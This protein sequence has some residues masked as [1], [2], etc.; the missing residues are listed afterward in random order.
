MLEDYALK[1]PQILLPDAR[2]DLTKWAVVACDQYTSQPDYWRRVQTLVGDAPSALNLI[3]PEAW[4]D[5]GDGR[6]DAINRAMRDYETTVLTRTITGFVLVERTIAAGRRLGLVAAVDLEQYDFSRGAQSLIRP[7]EGTILERIPPR[8]RI[9]QRASLE[10]P[11]ILLLVDDPARTLIEP[12]YAARDGLEKLYDFELMAGGG[13]IRGWRVGEEAALE[14]ALSGLMDRAEGLLFAVGDGN[15]SLAT[16]R[17]CWLNIRE[18][19]SP[20][21][22]QTHPARWALA[23]INNLHDPALVFEP[24]HRALFGADAQALRRDFAAWLAGRGMA[25]R[26]CA[27]EKAMFTL[28]A[29]GVDWPLRVEGLKNPLP[30]ATLQPFLDEWLAGQA[31]VSID[32]IHGEDA[33]RDLAKEGAVGILLPAM[34]KH[35]LFE[36]VRRGGPLPR[37]TFSMG[38]ANEKRY[39]LEARKIT[40]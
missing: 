13:H 27:S 9:R 36:S 10:L 21:E 20:E 32:Y 22:R 16:A 34:D 3:Y 33:L 12:L 38:E 17:Q 8:V 26:D 6:V 28:T 23:E 24:I 4:L 18:G 31:G 37:K 30:L 35:A 11:H 15:H 19:L 2:F 39:Y 40:E 29:E 14:P 1:M 5:Q 25:L 7:T